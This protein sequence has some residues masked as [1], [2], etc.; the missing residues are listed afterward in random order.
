MISNKDVALWFR[1]L[2]FFIDEMPDRTR[3]LEPACGRNREEFKAVIEIGGLDVVMEF[4]G[5]DIRALAAIDIEMAH[6]VRQGRR[7]GGAIVDLAGSIGV[8]GCRGGDRAVRCVPNQIRW[9]EQHG[10]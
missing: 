10:W 7:I 2:V 9:S 1:A 5:V 6:E 8:D 4:D 3:G